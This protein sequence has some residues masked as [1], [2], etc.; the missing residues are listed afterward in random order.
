MEVGVKWIPFAVA[1]R[2][3][4][5]PHWSRDPPASL[6]GTRGTWPGPGEPGWKPLEGTNPWEPMVGFSCWSTQAE[7]QTYAP[8]PFTDIPEIFPAQNA[9]FSG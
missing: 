6:N 2:E 8:Q 3:N 9:Q 1:L 4:Q 7:L 5:A